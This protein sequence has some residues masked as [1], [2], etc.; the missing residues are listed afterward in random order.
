MPSQAWLNERVAPT[1]EALAA[2]DGC[3]ADE[4]KALAEYL[5]GLTTPDE[6]ATRITTPVLAEIDPPQETYRLWSLLCEALVEL[7][8]EERHKTL[9]L[10][11]AVKKLPSAPAL[12]WS[13]MPGFASMWDTLYRLHLQGRD[14]WEADIN[15]MTESKKSQLRAHFSAVGSAE[16]EMF[17][18][19]IAPAAWGFKV[20]SLLSTERRGLDI[21]LSKIH[22]WLKVAGGRLRN[23]VQDENE[24]CST[25]WQVGQSAT[26][27]H[28]STWKEKLPSLSRGGSG[29]PEEGGRLA[30]DCYDLM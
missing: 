19:G 1:P 7:G 18:K 24:G 15:T 12:D 29:I 25:E 5:D 20:L 16:A 21:F 9:D 26:S 8:E 3:H 11:S 6:A 22:A 10:F 17:L 28:W 27:K 23:E 14:G 30:G 13:Q 4:A 2:G